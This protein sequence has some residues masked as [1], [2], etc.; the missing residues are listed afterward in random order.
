MTSLEIFLLI[1][2]ILTLI[3]GVLGTVEAI[4]SKIKYDVEPINWRMYPPV[5]RAVVF[6][7]VG[8]VGIVGIIISI[9]GGFSDFNVGT[10]PNGKIYFYHE[11]ASYSYP[12]EIEYMG[13]TYILAT[14]TVE[15]TDTTEEA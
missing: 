15:A 7:F 4:R 2:A 11:D 14:E 8:L 1:G 10:T 9:T 3:I 6:G 12:D 13:K 5:F